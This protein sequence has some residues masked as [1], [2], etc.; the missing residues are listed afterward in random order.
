MMRGRI[1]KIG[2]VLAE[3]VKAK[4][5]VAWVLEGDRGVTFA[6]APPEGSNVVA[7]RLV[8]RRLPGPAAG[9][10]RSRASPKGSA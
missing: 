7:G 9:L 4:E 2:D 8:G 3:N 1:V 6:S 10:A 5:S